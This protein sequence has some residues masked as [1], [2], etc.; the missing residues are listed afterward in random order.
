MLKANDLK[1][2]L[3]NPNI[4]QLDKLLLV[5]A[6]FDCP[7]QIKELRLVAREAGL[8][9]NR[10]WNPS[11][12][13]SR[14]NGYAIHTPLGWELTE[15]GFEHLKSLGV[16]RSHQSVGQVSR[17]LRAELIK[18]GSSHTRAFAEEA[19]RCLE[20]DLHRSAVVMSWI[21]AVAILQ[22]K[23]I[24]LK[25]AEFNAEAA[26]VDPKWKAA[27][28][29]DDL[30]KMKEQDFLDRLTAISII[31]KNVKQQLAECLTL[32]NGC[33]HPS[34]LQLGRNKVASHVETLI[35]NVFQGLDDRKL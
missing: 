25:L 4:T 27:K 1:T 9:M 31:G 2:Y 21:A 5:L 34:S 35:L 17:D 22:D 13:L 20:L 29:A 6:T 24:E 10:Q 19:I 16:S 8:K 23:V 30:G 26:R 32:R 33:G 11:S 12:S 7:C 15:A 18:I 28:T 14:S 3:H